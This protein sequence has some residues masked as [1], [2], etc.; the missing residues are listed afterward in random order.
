M[1]QSHLKKLFAGIHNIGLNKGSNDIY[2]MR[3]LEGEIVQ[4][5]KPVDVER[6]V[7]VRMHERKS[8]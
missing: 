8:S 1:L 7:E 5:D 2:E 3:S 6:P 4:L